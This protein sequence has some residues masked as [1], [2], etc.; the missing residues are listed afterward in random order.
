[1]RVGSRLAGPSSQTRGSP[2]TDFHP[3]LRDNEFNL[4]ERRSMPIPKTALEAAPIPILGCSLTTRRSKIAAKSLVLEDFTRKSF[5][6]KD[7][8]GISS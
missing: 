8:A 3:A 2:I 5:K 1:M 7:L 4:G 6:P